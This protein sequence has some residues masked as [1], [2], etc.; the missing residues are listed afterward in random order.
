MKQLRDAMRKE[1]GRVWR[2]KAEA[3]Q[4][5]LFMNEETITETVLF[6]L[7][8]EHL[9]S[10][11]RITPYKKQAEKKNGAD[12]EF[13]FAKGNLGIGLRVQA[14]RIFD[15]RTYQSLIPSS[16]QTRNLISNSNGRYP[17]FVFYNDS[18]SFPHTNYC[19]TRC[20]YKGPSYY[21]CS[22][23]S[24]YSVKS[25]R[26]NQA[27]SLVRMMAPWHCLLCDKPAQRRR[28]SLPKTVRRNLINL[29]ENS[30]ERPVPRIGELPRELMPLILT[31][32]D[33]RL[34]LTADNR[35]R[36]ERYISEQ[37]LAG[38]YLISNPEDA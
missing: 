19:K 38:L 30:S 6:S 8:R 9:T 16:P 5:G 4:L 24:A 21:G 31:D 15:D 36:I 10:E 32:P 3:E 27:A 22:I 25:S 14:K 20:G 1:A 37:S 35:E 17:V 18:Q 29:F 13:W 34:P 11:L 12:W 26:T 23:A 7:A 28:T 33:V 2:E